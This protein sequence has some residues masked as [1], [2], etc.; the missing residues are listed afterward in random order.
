MTRLPDYAVPTGEF[1][2][3]WMD[4]NGINAADLARRLD[5]TPKHVSELLH[6]KVALS[7][8]VAVSLERVTGIPA[9]YWSRIEATYRADLV[10]LASLSTLVEQYERI[11]KYP[12]K[13]LRKLGF[14]TAGL[15]DKA[16]VVSQVLSFFRV[17]SID[18]LERSWC[19]G[20]AFRKAAASSPQKESL[21]TW[22]TVAERCVDYSALEPF[23]K[24]ALQQ[25]LPSLRSLSCDSP[26][27]YTRAIIEMLAGVGVALCFV[28]EVSG[29]GIH[30]ATRWIDDH[31]VL[32]LSL[33]GKTDD[34]LW[35]TLF[36][37]IGHVLLHDTKNLYLEGS[38]T[39]NEVEADQFARD[40]LIPPNM[41]SG[42]PRGRNKDKIRQF[43]I[44]I[45]VSPGVV[46]GRVQHDS[47]DFGWGHDLKQH[48]EYS[49]PSA[50]QV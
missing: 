6:G 42:L 13:Y 9:E 29:L 36:H 32:Q 22:L 45:G 39:Q 19:Q 21:L 26:E 30:G 44:E 28:P 37:E 12:L 34:Q 33:R 18:A 17:A 16:T 4:D 8:D 46:L 14:V 48:F 35:F 3:E 11:D 50:I 47:G 24:A 1:V 43:A 5:V 7:A 10:R 15:K 38:G 41:I 20:V 25:L 2:K 31:P 27:T 49:F 23:D 40:I